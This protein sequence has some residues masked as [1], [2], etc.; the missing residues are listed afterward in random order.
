[1]KSKHKKQNKIIPVVLVIVGLVAVAGIVFAALKLFGL[2]KLLNN[3]SGGRDNN[4]STML[5]NT[6]NLH[7]YHSETPNTTKEPQTPA[8][9]GDFKEK[10]VIVN[11]SGDDPNTGETITGV[12]TYTGI[13]NDTLAI[14]VNIDQYV[15]E[16]NCMLTVAGSNTNYVEAARVI[17][18]AATSTCEGFNVPLSVINDEQVSIVIE[19]VANGKHGFI[20]GGATL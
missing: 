7:N 19:I 17:D 10:E 2:E 9:D 5:P 15:E 3:S 11:Y 8:N 20:N 4:T 12:I 1:M 13:A 16:G 18:A 6:E 14:R